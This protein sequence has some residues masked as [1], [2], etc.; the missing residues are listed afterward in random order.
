MHPLICNLLI[1]LFGTPKYLLDNNHY[2]QIIY[3]VHKHT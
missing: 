3:Y 2:S 1:A